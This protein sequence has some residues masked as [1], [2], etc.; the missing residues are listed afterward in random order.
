MVTDNDAR[1][2]LA[3]TGEH[4][5][6]ARSIAPGAALG[7]GSMAGADDLLAETRGTAPLPAFDRPP[8]TLA[9]VLYTSG[10]TGRPEG[11]AHSFASVSAS[12]NFRTSNFGQLPQDRLLV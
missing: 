11:D 4:L 5:A 6:R 12:M 1:F 8:E 3:L 7:Q 2:V 9:Q 10:T